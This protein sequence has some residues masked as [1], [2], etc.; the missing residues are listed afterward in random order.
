M[1]R[2]MVAT[3]VLALLLATAVAANADAW[4]QW[5][6]DQAGGGVNP[7]QPPVDAGRW[8]LRWSK[9]ETANRHFTTAPVITD[10]R[11]YVGGYIGDPSKPQV[12]CFDLATG[13]VNWVT[14]FRF[15]V[16]RG[17]AIAVLN[18]KVALYYGL[19]REQ[20]NSIPQRSGT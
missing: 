2:L 5:R 7:N 19:L 8:R 1:K 14:H 9:L 16:I 3:L 10:D 15:G 12:W 6:Y 13:H 20:R 18:G 4:S 11:L 17:G